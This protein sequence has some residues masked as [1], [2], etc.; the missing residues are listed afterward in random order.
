[1]ADT[2]SV[3]VYPAG[4]Q[5]WSRVDNYL[6]LAAR[7]GCK[8][9]FT[10][11]HLPEAD[12]D[13]QIEG[14]IILTELA[15]AHNLK[16]CCDFGG[17]LFSRLIENEELCHRVK[18]A[19]LNALRLDYGI[20]PERIE[21]CVKKLNIHSFQINAS[22]LSEQ[23]MDEIT[24]IEKAH[25]EWKLAIRGC[26]NFYPLIETGLDEDYTK[27][28]N[29]L[30]AQKG[31][32]VVCCAPC[33]RNPRGPMKQ[34]L[35]T[36]EAHRFLPFEEALLESSLLCQEILV[37]DEGLEEQDFQIV[38]RVVSRKPLVMHVIPAPDLADEERAILFEV[39]HFRPDSNNAVLRSQS[40][41]QMACYAA[42][43]PAKKPR[44]RTEGTVTI[45]NENALRYSGELQI[46]RKNLPANALC[47]CAGQIEQRDLWKLKYGL[48][49][50]DFR[51]VET[52][53]SE[54]K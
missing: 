24:E 35:P 42:N 53:G 33:H 1:M 30:C 52:A 3:A 17:T 40:S 9:I 36:V 29:K 23:E 25:P 5:D 32:P 20:S 47:N 12:A 48:E 34:G 19:G 46:A 4:D 6:A 49:G 10:S 44:L 43:V 13:D 11:A 21:D 8:E 22:I 14:V 37:G 27:K 26:H 15:H 54:M 51:I 41:R 16:I 18:A 39:H 7:Y 50:Y 31:W 28:Q 38:Q 2:Y 45:H